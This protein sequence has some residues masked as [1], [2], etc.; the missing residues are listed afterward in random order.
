[1]T[2]LE[3]YNQIFVETFGVSENTLGEDFKK[4]NV[5][6]WDSIHQLSI[7][8][9]IE[10]TFDLMLDSEEI[11]GLVSYESGLDILKKYKVEL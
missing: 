11:L 3:K 9:G 8:T 5:D 7:A 10:D 4:E 6:N 1:M 2:N